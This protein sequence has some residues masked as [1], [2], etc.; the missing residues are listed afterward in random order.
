MARLAEWVGAR[1]HEQEQG[2]QGGRGEQ[3][4]AGLAPLRAGFHA[5]PSMRQLH[6]HL[7]SQDLDSPCL[8]HKKH[9]NSFATSFFVPPQQWVAQLQASGGVAVDVA[10]EE[11]KLKRGMVC[12]ATGIPLRNIPALKE[13]L[14]SPEYRRALHPP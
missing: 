6:L 4:G 12:P 8:K 13:H 11:A 14:A 5:V 2:E 7:I 3:G 1:L 9:F 10:T